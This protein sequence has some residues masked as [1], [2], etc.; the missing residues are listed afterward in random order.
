MICFEQL[1]L[2]C[3]IPEKNRNAFY[4]LMAGKDLFGHKLIRSWGRIGTKE[5][6]RLQE[7]FPSQEEMTKTYRRILSI[8][9]SHGYI[10]KQGKEI[11]QGSAKNQEILDL[12]K[13][14]LMSNRLKVKGSTK[15][16]TQIF[17]EISWLPKLA[18]ALDTYA[19][20]SKNQISALE[21]GLDQ[22]FLLDEYVLERTIEAYGKALESYSLYNEQL[23]QWMSLNL[24]QDQLGEVQRLID[25]NEIVR[26][27]NERI[28]DLC[29]QI[30]H[31]PTNRIMEEDD[32]QVALDAFAGKIKFQN[33][34][35]I[36][37]RFDMAMEIDKFVDPILAGGGG[38]EDIVNHPERAHRAMQF[39]SIIGCAQLGEM[40]SLAQTF[41]GFLR[42][43]NLLENMLELFQQF[44]GLQR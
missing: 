4:R 5:K 9:L 26:A 12:K 25:V 11:G 16:K 2:E 38:D 34:G 21:K 13:E 7:R 40:D 41:P 8:R 17:R 19:E 24:S 15:R 1:Y 31:G 43:A 18:Q 28:I 37:D 35:S 44:K 36:D 27:R 42:F 14:I 30:K 32:V 22:Q 39:Q 20:N 3:K 10:V 23:N 29:N 6:I 33:P